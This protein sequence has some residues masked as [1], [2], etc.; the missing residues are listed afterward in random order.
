LWKYAHATFKEVPVRRTGPYWHTLSTD[1]G[2]IRRNGKMTEIMQKYL[3]PSRCLV[4]AKAAMYREQ[5]AAS[6]AKVQHCLQA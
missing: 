6:A 3:H 4:D 2:D 1:N 5:I